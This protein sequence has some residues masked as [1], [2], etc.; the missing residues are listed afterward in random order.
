M[1]AAYGVVKNHDGW[2]SV[3][4]E[5]GKGTI[6]RIYLP[7]AEVEVKELKKPKVVAPKSTGTLLAV[8]DEEIVMDVNR[9]ML[10]RLGYR[11][12]EAKTG[13]EAIEIAKTF[14]GDIDLALLDIVLP[15]MNAKDLYSLMMEARPNL[16]VLVC[17]GYSIDGPAQDILDAGA[18]GF[19]QKPFSVS[20][21]SEKL[22][23]VMESK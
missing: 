10:E 1:A 21:L 17:S 4:S 7:A 15:D 18:E 20:T 19:L 14:D 11:V 8:E 13:K 2:I 6:V 22:R 9:A 16:K 23:K 5:L 12:L 3:D